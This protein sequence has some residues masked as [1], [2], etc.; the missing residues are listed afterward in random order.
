MRITIIIIMN[1]NNCDHE[2]IIDCRCLLRRMKQH[3]KASL[4]VSFLTACK[5]NNIIPKFLQFRL[6]AKDI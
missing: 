6:W 1:N 4:D 5:Q 2:V 3:E